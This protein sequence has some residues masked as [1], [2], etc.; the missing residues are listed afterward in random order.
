MMLLKLLG[1]TLRMR[2]IHLMVL[3]VFLRGVNLRRKCVF[4]YANIYSV[5]RLKM[6]SVDVFNFSVFLLL[7]DRE[8]EGCMFS[9][10]WV[11]SWLLCLEA[12]TKSHE[13]RTGYLRNLAA[14]HNSSCYCPH[15]FLFWLRHKHTLP[16]NMWA[17]R[18][19]NSDAVWNRR[20]I[21]FKCRVGVG[22]FDILLNMSSFL[23]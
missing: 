22:A 4:S 13:L 7:R 21:G 3:T 19:S 1:K 12:T 17:A 8:I 11:I 14:E 2:G 5:R 16:Q 15:L 20:R 18:V 9:F 6:L 10:V 23:H